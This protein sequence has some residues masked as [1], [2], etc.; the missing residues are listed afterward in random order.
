MYSLPISTYSDYWRAT[1]V[2]S[3]Y[4]GGLAV[5]AAGTRY[6][7][8]SAPNIQAIPI[9][10]QTTQSLTINKLGTE[11]GLS[12]IGQRPSGQGTVSRGVSS[13]SAS[14]ISTKI[15]CVDTE[16]PFETQYIE[17]DKLL[18]GNSEIQEK[19]ER[20]YSTSGGKNV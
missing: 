8:M 15:E 20:R 6:S 5:F 4:I 1:K 12:D 16:I 10:Q 19:G 13:Q 17:S 9:F 7:V 14:K 11:V 2:W 3:S 18:P